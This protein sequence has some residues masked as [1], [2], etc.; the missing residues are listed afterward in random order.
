MFFKAAA[1]LPRGGFV[2]SG[3]GRTKLQLRKAEWSE[4]ER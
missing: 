1:G 4:A 3:K 2:V